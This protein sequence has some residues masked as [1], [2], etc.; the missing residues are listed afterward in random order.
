M[1]GLAGA[2]RRA[3]TSIA[4]AV[5][6]LGWLDGPLYLV[7]QALERSTGGRVRLVRYHV[8]AQ[9]IALPTAPLRPDAN[10]VIRAAL[11]GDPLADT[12][13]R[14]PAVI[15]GRFASGAGCLVAE[16]KQRFAGFLWWRRGRYEEDEVRCTF[17]LDQPASSA[18]DFDVYVDPAYR[19]GRTMARLW[20][21]ANERL[22]DEGVRWTCSRIS[23]F[24]AA[25]LASHARLGAR[26]LQRASFLVVGPW[27]LA[28]F[29]GRPFLHLSFGPSQVP[30]LPVVTPP[31]H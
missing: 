13:P 31:S 20:Q 12:F 6:S 15:A 25:S 5:S 28:V 2:F 3:R 18:W 14:P 23:A 29:S 26:R 1:P 17:V 19:H 7:A 10:T 21:A 9:P 24:N 30:R 27:Q 4:D 22:A 11:P 8:V 16:V